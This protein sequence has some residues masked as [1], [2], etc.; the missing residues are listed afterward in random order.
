MR[1]VRRRNNSQTRRFAAA[2]RKRLSG[3]WRRLW[4]NKKLSSKNCR[5]GCATSREAAR[6][7][8]SKARGLAFGR[9]RENRPTRSRRRHRTGRRE[10]GGDDSAKGR[11]AGAHPGAA[12]AGVRGIAAGGKRISRAGLR[13][14]SRLLACGRVVCRARCEVGRD[15]RKRGGDSDRRADGA[16]FPVASLWDCHLHTA[17]CRTTGHDEDAD[18]RR[19]EEHTSELQSRLHLVCR[20]LLEKKKNQT[21]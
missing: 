16:E 10:H 7:L 2:R 13:Y 15:A 14:R 5:S 18:S 11:G 20:L 17:I 19:S 12:N 4:R 6:P 1:S 21:I 8:G 9:N 3:D